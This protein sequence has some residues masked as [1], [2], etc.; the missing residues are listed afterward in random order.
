MK[1]TLLTCAALAALF[2]G[3]TSAHADAASQYSFHVTTA[4]ANGQAATR[5]AKQKALSLVAADSNFQTLANKHISDTAAQLRLSNASQQMRT[6]LT[7][8]KAALASKTS[9]LTVSDQKASAAAL[10]SA[11]KSALMSN[12]V[13]GTAGNTISYK[14]ADGSMQSAS[15]VLSAPTIAIVTAGTTETSLRGLGGFWKGQ[16]AADK[17]ALVGSYDVYYISALSQAL[18]TDKLGCNAF[19]GYYSTDGASSPTFTT[20]GCSP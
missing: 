19:N 12:A 10:Q 20:A 17:A 15:F 2:A 8:S 9:T 5:A 1:L 7:N 11:Y 14:S 16:I 18:S 13:V 6:T 4:T 3:S